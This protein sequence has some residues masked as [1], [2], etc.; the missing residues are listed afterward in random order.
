MEQK[1]EWRPVITPAVSYTLDSRPM[2]GMTYLEHP[3]P[4]VS[5]D[6]WPMEG[7]S[8]LRPLEQSVLNSSIAARPVEDVDRK[9]SN[10][11]PVKNPVTDVKSENTDASDDM[12]T[13]P[14]DR[15]L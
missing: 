14:P 2:E 7:A 10:R 9:V 12:N 11:K 15:G 4:G 1:S 6:S 8:C 5:L 13:D 3:A